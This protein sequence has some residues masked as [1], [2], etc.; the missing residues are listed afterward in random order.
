MCKSVCDVVLNRII[1]HLLPLEVRFQHD[2]T[3]CNNLQLVLS[4]GLLFYFILVVVTT[5]T[6][7]NIMGGE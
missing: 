7:C 6:T 4:H 3:V 2:K 5:A 1:C